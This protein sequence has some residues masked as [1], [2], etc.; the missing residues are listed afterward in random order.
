MLQNILS[1]VLKSTIKENGFL[2]TTSRVISFIIVN[3]TFLV[4]R[5]MFFYTLL[6]IS[7]KGMLWVSKNTNTG[8]QHWYIKLV[9]IKKK[10]YLQKLS[11][12]KHNWICI[13]VSVGVFNDSESTPVE[14]RNF[15]T[16]DLRLGGVGG[17]LKTKPKTTTE[18]IPISSETP[19]PPTS[20]PFLP[21]TTDSAYYGE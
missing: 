20:P 13:F 1:A 12:Q 21:P 16:T 9:W 11:G 18:S 10:N 17:G 6:L 5:L 7:S 8:S 3:N 4:N 2:N 19:E 15:G 14:S